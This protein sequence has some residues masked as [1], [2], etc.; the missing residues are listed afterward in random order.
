MT[1][2]Y[3]MYYRQNCIVPLC[4]L[5]FSILL[6]VLDVIGILKNK[7]A[8]TPKSIVVE[9]VF[10]FIFVFLIVVNLAP[11]IRGGI[12]LLSEKESDKTQ[13]SGVIEETGEIGFYTGQKYGVEQNLGSGETITI[14]GIKYYLVTYGD[15]R[16]GDVVTLE[17][18]PRSKFV[19]SIYK[20]E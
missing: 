6:L 3:N 17:V 8:S 14:D 20:K 15:Y 1:F 7:Q 13:I 10:L 16:E 19:L 5:V 2:D 12:Y 18:L 4:L 11:L 9:V